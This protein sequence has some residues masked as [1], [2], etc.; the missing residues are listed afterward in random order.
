MIDFVDPCGSSCWLWCRSTSVLGTWL[1]RRLYACTS[2]T[3][4]SGVV[5]LL[6]DT[7][8][9]LP[10]L[11]PFVFCFIFGAFFAFDMRGGGVVGWTTPCQLVLG[12]FDPY[13]TMKL[14]TFSKS[15]LVISGIGESSRSHWLEGPAVA[16]CG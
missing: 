13:L 15:I 3:G 9:A 14:L 1:Q 8:F 12:Q 5:A 10:F 11:S 6:T 7:T 16:F 2:S 4:L